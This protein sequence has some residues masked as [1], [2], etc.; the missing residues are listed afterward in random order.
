MLTYTAA[1]SMVFTVIDIQNRLKRL[2]IHLNID[3]DLDFVWWKDFRIEKLNR[4][5]DML[6]L[7]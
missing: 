1:E 3:M 7:L 2:G 6:I 5:G 4:K